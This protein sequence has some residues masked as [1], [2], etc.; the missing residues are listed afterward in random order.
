[1]Y[2]PLKAI[3]EI[4]KRAINEL[5]I[6]RDLIPEKIEGAL[7]SSISAFSAAS[8]LKSME[9]DLGLSVRFTREVARHVRMRASLLLSIVRAS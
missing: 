8:S 5:N 7:T 3:R 9:E 6:G 1:V 2:L 4:M